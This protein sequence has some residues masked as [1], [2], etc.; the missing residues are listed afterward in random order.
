MNSSQPE[1]TTMRAVIHTS[2]GLPEVLQ[3]VQIPRPVPNDNEVLVKIHAT[4]VNR[5]DC[6]FRQPE[7]IF[8]RLFSGMFKPKN[9]ILGSE[10]SGVVEA[11]GKS[12]SEF[13]TG[14]EIFG[15]NTYKFGTHAE[16]I[17][18]PEKGSITLK[19]VNFSHQEAAAIC[20][21]AFL[22]LNYIRKINFTKNP[23]ILV[24]GASGSIGTACVQLA[25]YYG[26]YVTAVCNTKNLELLKKLGADSV[27]DY[28]REDFTKVKDQYDVVLD[29]VGKSSFFK[30]RKILKPGGIYFSTELGFLSQ[31]VFLALGTGVLNF[32][33]GKQHRKKVLFPIPAD[34]KEDIVFF[35]QLAEAGK[36]KAVID[37]VYPLEQ[38]IE[39][40]RYV[41]T[42]EKTGNVVISV[43]Q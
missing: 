1:N 21:G 24:N 7:Y 42:G 22:A 33:P 27:I 36:Y 30:C 2:Y 31:N 10:L 17:C 15:L 11:T 8:V 16:Y 14:D 40:T 13:K 28:T 35:R 5:T 25:K 9:Q 4:T 23:K 29:A 43:I 20:D 3:L 12:V 18:V 37:R 26:G 32:L 6:G 41:E 19:P 39:A 38:I 34:C